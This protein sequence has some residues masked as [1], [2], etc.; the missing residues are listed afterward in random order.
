[1][2][3]VKRKDSNGNMVIVEVGGE[4]LRT[5]WAWSPARDFVD[6]QEASSQQMA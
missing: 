3:K 5:G 6:S 1:M 2:K 4:R